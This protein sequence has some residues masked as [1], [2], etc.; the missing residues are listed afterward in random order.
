MLVFFNTMLNV[1]EC[2]FLLYVCSMFE[3]THNKWKYNL[4]FHLKECWIM[5]LKMF[6]YKTNNKP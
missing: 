5:T 6:E 1:D 4:Y 3:V 2:K